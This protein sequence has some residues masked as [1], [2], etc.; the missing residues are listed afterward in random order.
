MFDLFVS[1]RTDI[2]LTQTTTPGPSFKRRGGRTDFRITSGD[3]AQ[4]A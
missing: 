1:R 4:A 3:D 2:S